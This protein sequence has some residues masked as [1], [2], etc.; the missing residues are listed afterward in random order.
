MTDFLSDTILL[1]S[2]NVLGRR[3]QVFEAHIPYSLQFMIDYSLYG[4]NYVHYAAAKFRKNHNSSRKNSQDFRSAS[5]GSNSSV[6]GYVDI[7]NIDVNMLGP[8][9]ITK[10]TS[11]ELEI[12]VKACDILM[13]TKTSGEISYMWSSRSSRVNQYILNLIF[14]INQKRKCRKI[15]V[16]TASGK[17]K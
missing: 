10:M 6:P 5:Q 13:E 1:Q 7:D 4:M 3:F 9:S 11:C 8:S 16:L 12:D 17:T 14:I 15:L 2:G